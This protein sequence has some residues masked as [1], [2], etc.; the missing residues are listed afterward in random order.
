M[1]YFHLEFHCDI[2][3]FLPC[4]MIFMIQKNLKEKKYLYSLDYTV[5]ILLNRTLLFPVDI[6]GLTSFPDY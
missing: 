4:S 6:S 2:I 5:M 1:L 3:A